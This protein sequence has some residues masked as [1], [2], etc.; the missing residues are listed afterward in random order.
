MSVED[1]QDC[2]SL[3]ASQHVNG[4]Q[5]TVTEYVV[6]VEHDRSQEGG[7]SSK[8][9]AQ[10]VCNH[11][12]LVVTTGLRYSTD[13]CVP[14][15]VM[16][17]R[18]CCSYSC[19]KAYLHDQGFVLVDGNWKTACDDPVT[20]GPTCDEAEEAGHAGVTSSGTTIQTTQ[21]VQKVKPSKPKVYKC[22]QCGCKVIREE[23]HSTAD[24]V[25]TKVMPRRYC[26]S[27]Q[28]LIAIVMI[29]LSLDNCD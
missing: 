18:V 26:C 3:L 4:Y 17:R 2:L 28:C 12:G 7:T 16:T 10:V 15:S 27:Y 13:K 21:V 14:T 19:R 8:P 1:S 24:Y 5:P 22:E 23:R 6:Q 9:T 29:A 11:C 20:S 25:S